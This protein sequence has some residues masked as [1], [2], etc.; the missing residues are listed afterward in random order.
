[1]FDF[2]ISSGMQHAFTKRFESIVNLI[3]L[4]DGSNVIDSYTLADVLIS[5][6]KLWFNRWFQFLVKR[7]SIQNVEEHRRILV[8]RMQ[9]ML[10][11][12]VDKRLT[13]EGPEGLYQ[14][15]IICDATNNTPWVVDVVGLE[16]VIYFN[17]IPK[18]NEVHYQ[19]ELTAK[20]EDE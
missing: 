6:H 14:F 20:K 15:R 18:I 4:S 5:C 8:L 2:E 19:L 1:M 7:H 17:T 9:N 3:A 10:E 11:A 12:I 16:L 13:D